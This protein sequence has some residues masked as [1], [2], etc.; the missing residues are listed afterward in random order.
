MAAGLSIRNQ[1]KSIEMEEATLA[2]EEQVF[3]SERNM[4]GVEFA[5]L[6]RTVIHIF[7]YIATQALV[8]ENFVHIASKTDA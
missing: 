2:F 1:R 3:E 7:R 6:R 4:P 5:Q 8:L